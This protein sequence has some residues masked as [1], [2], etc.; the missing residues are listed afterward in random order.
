MAILR[1]P[2]VQQLTGL[3]KATI[4]RLIG[5]K[6]FPAARRLSKQSVGWRRDEIDAWIS[7]LPRASLA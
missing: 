4:Y 2:Q 6:H 3:S 1:L 5:E 7:S